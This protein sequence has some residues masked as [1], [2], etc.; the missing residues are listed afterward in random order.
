M[1]LARRHWL[2]GQL[3]AELGKFREAERDLL[4]AHQTF[5]ERQG[6]L[7]VF[8]ISLDLAH[9]YLREGKRRQARDLL[10]EAIPLGEKV[11]GT[12]R[13]ILLARWFYEQASRG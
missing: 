13:E 5:L 2:E 3:A 11:G 6:G 12:R 9:V 4:R 10:R 7:E 1:T 8:L